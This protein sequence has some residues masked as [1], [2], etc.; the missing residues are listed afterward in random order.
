M[1]LLKFLGIGTHKAEV[2]VEA[3]KVEY[4]FI[5]PRSSRERDTARLERVEASIKNLS[6]KENKPDQVKVKIARLKAEAE[7]LRNKL[8]S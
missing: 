7:G 1:G 3:P 5:S 6:A 8:A 2:V 4:V